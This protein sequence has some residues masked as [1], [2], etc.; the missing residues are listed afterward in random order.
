MSGTFNINQINVNITDVIPP[1]NFATVDAGAKIGT[2]YTKDQDNEWRAEVEQNITSGIKGIA[3]PDDTVPATGF[4][5]MLADTATIYTNYIGTNDAPI[6]VTDADLNIVNGV[7]RNEVIFDV[8]DGVTEK[9]VFA[10]I[11]ADGANGTASIPKWVAGDYSPDAMVVNDFVQYVAPTG[12]DA[13]DIPGESDKWVS[14]GSKISE[15]FNA[16]TTSEAQGG[17]QIENYLFGR[18][19]SFGGYIGD[20]NPETENTL[21]YP[22]IAGGV[23]YAVILRDNG[24]V[25][26]I[27]FPNMLLNIVKAGTLTIEK[28]SISGTTA[29]QVAVYQQS[30]S[31]GMVTI[32]LPANMQVLTPNQF[33]GFRFG[34]TSAQLGTTAGANSIYNVYTENSTAASFPVTTLRNDLF[35]GVKVLDTVYTPPLPSRITEFLANYQQRNLLVGIH[36]DYYVDT[37]NIAQ[38]T[39]GLLYVKDVPLPKGTKKIRWVGYRRSATVFSGLAFLLGIKRDGT[40]VKLIGGEVGTTTTLEDLTVDISSDIIAISASSRTNAL[41][42]YQLIALYEKSDADSYLDANLESENLTKRIEATYTSMYTYL[43]SYVQDQNVTRHNYTYGVIISSVF[44]RRP[45][46]VKIDR[47]T[48]KQDFYDISQPVASTVY[49]SAPLDSHYSYTIGI[50]K[51]NKVIVAGGCHASLP[52]IAIANNAH[53]ITSWS[54]TNFTGSTQ[55]TYI[56]FFNSKDGD[57]FAVWR[58]GGSG[59]GDT[60]F[61]RFNETTQA[62]NTKTM[63]INGSSDGANAYLQKIVIDRNN[64]IKICYGY[65]TSVSDVRTNYGMFY[66]ESADFGV[67]WRNSV[68]VSY[69]MPLRLVNAEKIFDAPINSGYINQNGSCLDINNNFNTVITQKRTVSGITTDWILRIYKSGASW[70]TEWTV[71]L[72]TNSVHPQM[73]DVTWGRPSVF[74][75]LNNEIIIMWMDITRKSLMAYNVVTKQKKIL[76]NNYESESTFNTSDANFNNLF[77]FVGPDRTTPFQ[78]YIFESRLIF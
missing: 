46:V 1:D 11:G 64:V 69:T 27:T 37:S 58:E 49:Q 9:K 71:D 74:C 45:V 34:T 57:L 7:Q 51:S 12:A 59:N 2:V 73:Q 36:P 4:F 53:D 48:N 44:G 56:R 50:T 39:A 66:L 3:K 30:V 14:M 16:A 35:L 28:L 15:N 70:L 67:T 10:K 38:A 25:S 23:N 19:E 76:L 18:S 55:V 42:N 61:A 26:D 17:K 32:N 47:L 65:R 21:L 13:T 5:R 77:S 72:G 60:Y 62:F 24:R 43:P 8:T 63:L 29:T 6:E 68:G 41:K 52:I 22:T 33:Y 75:N 20:V 78:T 40:F 31:V 54:F